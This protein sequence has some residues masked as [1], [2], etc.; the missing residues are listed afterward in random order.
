MGDC[1]M[2]RA[3]RANLI[4]IWVFVVM[5]TSIA[6]TNGIDSGI[7]TMKATFTAGILTTV[8]YFIPFN[9][10]VK[11]TIIVS[12]P[13]LS[14]LALSVVQGGE[15][16]MFNIYILSLAMQALYFNR[17]LMI[18]YGSVL[19]LLLFV[20]YFTSPAALVGKE[21]ALVEFISPMGALICAFIVL[22]LLTTWGQETVA[23]AQE[24]GR[25]SQEALKKLE[26]IFDEISASTKMLGDKSIDCRDKMKSGKESAESTANAIKE[27]ASSVEVAASTVSNISKS[28]SVSSESIKKVYETMHHINT[29]FK[30]TMSDV[31]LS[32]IAVMNVREQIDMIK[33]AASSSYETIKELSERTEEIHGFLDGIANISKQTNLLALNASIEAARAGEH[34]RGFAIVAEE[35]RNLS[36]QSGKLAGGI[37]DIIMEF[38]ESTNKAMNEVALGQVAM[39]KG[40]SSMGTLDEKFLSMKKSFD[41]VG[42]KIREEFELVSTIKSEFIIIDSDIINIAATLEENAAHFEEISARTELQTNVT[43]EVANEMI[44]I[45]IIGDKLNE[46]IKL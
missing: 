11:G 46:L 43:I 39:N 32:E 13:A 18:G 36:E 40:Y 31:S 29:Y 20:I 16:R 42:E 27:L 34:G 15:A 33:Q 1:N 5:L 17:K 12:I 41:L 26:I 25:R 6:F 2:K 45:A 35:I 3:I 44:D 19:S 28:S 7:A 22:I 21:A 10:K 4:F 30:D 37:R 24:E 23:D 38:M 14:S 8:I 9:E